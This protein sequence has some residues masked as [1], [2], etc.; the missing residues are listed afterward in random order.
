LVG[1]FLLGL[2]G[3]LMIGLARFLR[4]RWINH[5]SLYSLVWTISLCAYQ[6]RL[7][8]YNYISAE[9]WVFI[10]TAWVALYLGTAWAGIL[11]GLNGCRQ[12]QWHTGGQPSLRSAIIF[13]SC[14]GLISSVVLAWNIVHS[15]DS[16]LLLA[17]VDQGNKIYTMRFEGDLSGLMY[18]GFLPYAASALAGAHAARTGRIT[19]VSV[20]PLLAMTIDGILSMQRGGI[21][22]AIVLFVAGMYITPAKKQLHLARWHMV[23]S[24][25]IL[26][27]GFFYVTMIRG[28]PADFENQGAT[29]NRISDVVPSL[30][31]LYMYVSAPPAGLSAYLMNSASDGSAFWGRYTFAPAFRLLARFGWDTYVPYYTPFYSTPVPINTCTYLREIHSD[32][33]NLGVFA[34]PF[35]LGALVTLL[36]ARR[37]SVAVQMVLAHLYVVILFSFTLLIVITGY[38]YFSLLVSTIAG[39]LFD[40]TSKPAGAAGFVPQAAGR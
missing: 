5:L 14:A 20:L 1:L 17:L 31:S 2:W 38:W 40:R 15:L 12:G 9:A 24:L 28:I 4:G 29:L 8:E 21:L 30:P 22:I 10:F 18:V 36:E 34:V 13:L 37:S 23:A 16:Q 27:T 3:F 25:G 26:I 32:F 35:C 6:L 11:G 19:F 39:R 7:I 33:G